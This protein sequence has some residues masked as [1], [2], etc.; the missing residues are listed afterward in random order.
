[1]IAHFLSCRREAGEREIKSAQ[2]D[3]R[4][5]NRAYHFSSNHHYF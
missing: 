5:T 3:A 2:G 1:M 4:G